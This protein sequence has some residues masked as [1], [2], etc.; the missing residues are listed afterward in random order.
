MA[1]VNTNSK[2]FKQLAKDANISESQLELLVHEFINQE[3]YDGKSYPSVDYINQKLEGKE[4][5]CGV[6]SYKLWEEQYSKPIIVNTTQEMQSTLEQLSQIYDTNAIGVKFTNNGKIEI[7]IKKPIKVNDV[8]FQEHSTELLNA[9]QDENLRQFIKN[10]QNTTISVADLINYVKNKSDNYNAVLDILERKKI[11]D[12]IQ[13]K[14]HTEADYNFVPQRERNANTHVGRQAKRAYFSNGVIHIN[15]NAAFVDGDASSVAM[16]EIMHAVTANKLAAN[17]RLRN[18]FYDIIQQYQEN[19]NRPYPIAHQYDYKSQFAIDH[20]V[21]EFVADIWSDPVLIEELKRIEIEENGEKLTLWDK[22]KQFFSNLFTGDLFRGIKDKSLMAKAS[23]TM[24]ELLNSVEESPVIDQQFHEHQDSFNGL[25][26]KE[27]FIENNI[28]ARYTNNEI[29]LNR[30]LLKQKYKDKAWA[31]PRLQ[32]DGSKANALSENQF[33]SY[34]EFEQF[35]LTHEY[36]HNVFPRDNSFKTT[37]E[38]ETFI[39]E[40]ALQELDRQQAYQNKQKKSF[41]VEEREKENQR[42]IQKVQ[43][44]RK[45]MNQIELANLQRDIANSMSDV[46]TDAFE[47]PEKFEQLQNL[48]KNDIEKMTRQQMVEKIGVDNFMN[49]VFKTFAGNK[50][51]KFAKTRQ[52]LVKEGNWQTFVRL[53]MT[54]FKEHEKFAIIQD[55]VINNVVESETIN[56]NEEYNESQSDSE[57]A[58]KGDTQEHWQVEARSIE[59]EATLSQKVRE[60][61]NQCYLL[62][63]DASGELV[64]V[65]TDNAVDKR[66]EVKDATYQI[67]SWTEGCFTLKEMIQK[68]EAQVE[69]SPWVT[70]ILEKLQD[71]TGKYTDFQSQFFNNFCKSMQLYSVVRRKGKNLISNIVNRNLANKVAIDNIIAAFNVGQHPLFTSSGV[72][73]KTELDNFTKLVDQLDNLQLNDQSIGKIANLTASAVA[74]LGF[75]ASENLYA[76]AIN[77]ENYN[78]LVK[79]LKL[80]KENLIAN[81][82]NSNYSPFTYKSD[83]SIYNYVKAVVNPIAMLMDAVNVNVTVDNGK[84]Y[85]SRT[86]PSY[87]TKLMSKFKQ[88]DQAKFREFVEKEYGQ[89]EW[90]AS[91]DE[92]GNYV[93]R[94]VWLDKL[95]KDPNARKQFEHKVQLNYNKKKYMKEMNSAEYTV[96]LIAEYFSETRGNTNAIVPAWFRVPMLSNKPSSEFIKFDSYRGVDYKNQLT[97]NFFK[98]FEQELSRIQTCKRRKDAGIVKGDKRYIKNFDENGHKF[99]LLDFMQ[100]EVDSNTKLGQLIDKKLNESKK[101][102]MTSAEIRQLQQL[103]KEKIKTAIDEK[104][105]KI[106]EQWEKNGVIAKSKQVENV[107]VKDEIVKENLRNFIWNDAFASIQ[108]M[109]L[110]IT[111]P[112]Y[113]KDA[114][115]LQKRMAEIHAPGIRG[116]VQATDYN[117][118]A[119]TD[120]QLRTVYIQDS[121]I[122]SNV[123]DN[124]SEVFDRKIDE[125][126]S[127]EQKKELQILKDSLVGENGA[128]RAVNVTDAQAYTGLTALRKKALMLGK[129]NREKEDLYQ[130]IK[131][132]E[133]YSPKNIIAFTQILKPFVYSQIEKSANA[134]DVPMSKLKVPVQNKNSEYLLIMADALL[135]NEKTTKPN[136][137]KVISEV[138]EES[139]K[140]EIVDGKY[141]AGTKGI[142]V[143]QFNSTVKSGEQGVIDL[144]GLENEEDIKNTLKEAIYS[145]DENGKAKETFALNYDM[146]IVHH[147]PAEDYAEQQSVP[148]HFK[149]HQQI[150]GS[151]IRAIIEGDQQN[152]TYTLSDGRQLNRQEF[153]EE[154]EKTVAANVWLSID[155]LKEELQ[156]DQLDLHTRNMIISRILQKEILS[157]PRYGIDMAIA[158]AINPQTGKFNIPLGDP[159]QSK[160]IEQLINSI[161]KNR[162]NKQTI[163]GGPVVQVSNFG[164]SKQLNIRFKDKN[165]NLLQTRE[166]WEKLENEETYENYIKENQSGIAYWEVFAPIYSDEL[167][168]FADKNGNINIKAIEK[169]NS[170]LLELIGYRI[171]TEDKYSMAPLKIVGFLP[172]EAGDAIMLPAEI[173]T[174][175]GSDFDVD[176]FYLMRKEL[177]FKFKS[178]SKNSFY[179]ILIDGKNYTTAQKGQIAKQVEDFL[180]DPMSSRWSNTKAFDIYMSMVVEQKKIKDEKVKNNN[181][182]ID[183][184]RAVL[185]SEHN[186]DRML[187]PGGFEE[188]KKMGYVIQAL[189]A[190]PKFKYDQLMKLSTKELK[191]LGYRSKNLIFVDEQIGFYQ[192]NSAASSLIST[193]AVH[194]SSHSIYEGDG[195]GISLY[196]LFDTGEDVKSFSIGST[197]FGS[198]E[199]VNVPIEID[200]TFDSQGILISKTLGSTLAASVDAVKDPV[201]NLTNINQTTSSILEGMLRVGVPFEEAALFLAQKPIVDLIEEIDNSKLS[202]PKFINQLVDEK[203]FNYNDTK[204]FSEDLSKEEMIKNLTAPTEESAIKALIMLKR[205]SKLA[206]TIQS[207]SLISRFN[208]ISSA[209]GP[210]II[211]N[212]IM[213]AKLR[214]FPQSIVDKY[215]NTVTVETI[216]QNH[217]ML[218]SFYQ[219]YAIADM[220]FSQMKMPLNS[221]QF[222]E[223]LNTFP[224]SLKDIMFKDRALLSKFG[225]FYLSYK[226]INDKDYIGEYKKPVVD[227]KK[228]AYYKQDFVKDYL[229]ESKKFND[230]PL[231][232][233]IKLS[234]NS[235]TGYVDLKL[236]QKGLTN[237]EK[238]R[239]TAGWAE[240]WKGE[241]KELARKLFEYNFFKGGIEFSPKTIISLLPLQ[242]H[243]ELE[244]YLNVFE[245]EYSIDKQNLVDQFIRNNSDNVK[246]VPIIKDAKLTALENN[247]KGFL[248]ENLYAY[249]F[250]DSKGKMYQHIGFYQIDTETDGQQK[251]CLYQEIE[252][253]GIDGFIDISTS[254]L[255]KREERGRNRSENREKVIDYKGMTVEE[256]AAIVSESQQQTANRGI[257]IEEMSIEEAQQ[258]DNMLYD[259]IDNTI[260]EDVTNQLD[261][262]EEYDGRFEDANLLQQQIKE[263]SIQTFLNSAYTLKE[264]Q[265]Y[266]QMPIEIKMQQKDKIIESMKEK[267]AK[268]NNF[269]FDDKFFN[270]CLEKLC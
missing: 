53:A 197:T 200:P 22:V 150:Y 270:D 140:G 216:F 188:Q 105:D 44:L 224:D 235:E 123:I 109:E 26:I 118:K 202:K 220:L 169:V 50:S 96:S 25:S 117:G 245:N 23:N 236:D 156:L 225:N 82:D 72:V 260:D 265:A 67:L 113:Y 228:L 75:T 211:D 213:Q 18:T 162:V 11:L 129:W 210:L 88:T 111:D 83:G 255:K 40:K 84:M 69:T 247:D 108:I 149:E 223:T 186:T 64:R 61:L 78:S 115:D 87:L 218:E 38:Y 17:P 214:N 100:N 193:F 13:V 135:S 49:A 161:I 39:N 76:Q 241:G 15:G 20:G 231:I 71:T 175:T 133:K 98:V 112:A 164:T 43:T 134:A 79:N 59:T 56:N 219:S 166:E 93:Y 172:R 86:I 5:F 230:N 261:F 116:N 54:T 269:K 94:N 29:L 167:L 30:E 266:Q 153:R 226:L 147:Y 195:M 208:S 92:S 48:S 81:Q 183:M 57:V 176:K 37:G 165:G 137:L 196:T 163:A 194:K 243:Q 136:I 47:H 102:P 268:F 232:Q 6:Q 62:E 262:V 256:V 101:D 110:T 46:I 182:L 204:L 171:P 178:I 257:Q 70:Q 246:L 97:E 179:N 31:E 248:S 160:I 184:T 173:T 250:K 99:Q 77:K 63:K 16:H 121:E 60:V 152:A 36:M 177:P 122:I 21:A 125:A 66:I 106:L 264:R 217:P 144:N 90:F 8:S 1:C 138:M 212:L 206:Q 103:T 148:E 263:M 234:V 254:K 143:I 132:G 127:K 159:L 154:Y 128:Y 124:I 120:G 267:A 221:M 205:M 12:N 203:I 85:Q 170:E 145:T 174:I 35:V 52:L 107:G 91:L 185:T 189:K 253:L 45:E 238:E 24:I 74:S 151:Q 7:S 251:M 95:M 229:K 259:S 58:E 227:S 198:T 2:A 192:Q 168:K 158:C 180:E 242:M 9:K 73:N 119:I 146:D 55:G 4:T 32:K 201:L 233:A 104:A 258:F 190:N 68:L 19:S 114:E 14:V 27:G 199:G 139:E 244:G 34:E 51:L 41:T 237:V 80:I 222:A 33:T 181:H 42:F 240:L 89:Y 142:D 65:K 155:K 215:G 28:A 187:N 239:L 209:V 249:M 141:V 191:K 10:N 252:P 130:K 126:T 131:K 157:N 207:V 3:G